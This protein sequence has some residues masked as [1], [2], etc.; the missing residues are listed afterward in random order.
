MNTVI[1]P[2]DFSDISLN[3]ARY[4][5]KLLTGHPEVQIILYHAYD[6][7]YAEENTLENL[8]KFKEE[9]L[10][11]REANITVLAEHGDFL[12]ELEKL[13]RHR[14]A[15]LIV[16][17]I[18]GK[19]SLAQVF[20]GSNALK[21]AENKFCPVMIIPSNAV[22]SEIKNVL[23]TTDLKNVVSTTPS[24]PIKKILS[25]F[26]AKLHIVNVNSEHYIELSEDYAAELQKL[27]DM[28]PDADPEFY[29]L[30][31]YDVDDAI[32]TFAHDKNIDLII[33]VHKEHSMVHKLFMTSHTKKLAYQSTVPVVVVH[34]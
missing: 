25:T 7:P 28:F 8:S 34:E 32:N 22:Y 14:Q 30:R 20:M 1:V 3:A 18:T 11:N 15:D 5:V 33:T 17:G 29:F 12:T 10:Q 9:L 23:L 6:N 21:M 31:L 4:A 24:A 16:M 13:A 19:S 2:V 27:K 26:N